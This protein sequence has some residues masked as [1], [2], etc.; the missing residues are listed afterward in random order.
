VSSIQQDLKA[1]LTI[2]Y[3]NAVFLFLDCRGSFVSRLGV[4]VPTVEVVVSIVGVVVSRVLDNFLM[5]FSLALFCF[6]S[7]GR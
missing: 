5:I 1:R 7:F 4:V 2:L 3:G 6:L